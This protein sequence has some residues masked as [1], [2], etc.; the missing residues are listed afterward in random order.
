[1]VLD[2][3]S[4]RA[5][6]PLEAARIGATAVGTD[7]SPVATLAGRLLADY[8]SR[9]WSSEPPLP[10]GKRDDL[11]GQLSALADGRRLVDDVRDVLYEVGRRVAGLAGAA[12]PDATTRGSSPGATCGRSRMPCDACSR[13][14]PLLGSM[15][16]KHPNVKTGDA[17]QSI[18]INVDGDAWAVEVVSGVPRQD[19]TYSAS[20]RGDGKKRK[21]KAA[22]CVFCHHVHSLE[23]V[24]A[25][26][27]AGE[28]RD[29]LIVV[30]DYR[31]RSERHYRTPTVRRTTRQPSRLTLRT[32]RSTAAR[33]APFPT[34]Q[35]PRATST[36]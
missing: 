10:L 19:P 11:D 2:V 23:T 6:I 30:A 9:D 16:L 25:K 33:T 12:L 15:L 3:F 18:E 8:P 21:G 29:E 31:S 34:R 24:K 20:D 1:M 13:R 14:F 27:F 26:G 17:G 7:L 36:P 35:S 4:G 22:R 32:Y 28:Y 5:I